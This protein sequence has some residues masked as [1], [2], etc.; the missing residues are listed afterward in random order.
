MKFGEQC[1]DDDD[2]YY[3]K[4]V[5]FSAARALYALSTHP[6]FVHIFGGRVV[7]ET[8]VHI[9]MERSPNNCL[10]F[11]IARSRLNPDGPEA[12]LLSDPNYL[13]AGFLS[14]I[15]GL[16]FLEKFHIQHRDIKPANVLAFADVWKL[17]DFGST[18]TVN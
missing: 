3:S 9:W 4:N 5:S 13:S 8:E 11:L 12:Q 10:A 7:S 2:K 6:F 15:S 17:A 14:L 16:L 1:S 18:F